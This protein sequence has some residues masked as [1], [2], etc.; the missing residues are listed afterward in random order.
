MWDLPEESRTI[1]IRAFFQA[2][3]V[4]G[5]K[6]KVF[7]YCGG[8]A[9]GKMRKKASATTSLISRNNL[10][11]PGQGVGLNLLRGGDAQRRSSFRRDSHKSF[12]FV[13]GP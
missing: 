2:K 5:R 9:K 11:R 7:N 8:Q 4:M 6:A 3:T 12:K 1:P 13:G 10:L